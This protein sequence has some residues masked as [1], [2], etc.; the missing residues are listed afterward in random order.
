MAIQEF[1]QSLLADARKRSDDAARRRRKEEERAAILGV[2]V[3]LAAKIGN[4][5]LA[6]KAKDFLK[7]EEFLLGQRAQNK[8]L[9]YTAELNS[10]RNALEQGGEGYSAGDTVG[11]AMYKLRPEFEARA[12][13]T[14]SNTYTNDL[15]AY[16]AKVRQET[17]K[18]A[19][20]WAADYNK[21]ILLA[22]EVSDKDSYEAMVALN[23]TKAKP[24]NIGGYVTRGISK[25]FGGKSEEEFEQEAFEAITDEMED[26]EELT[27]FM[28]TFKSFGDMTRA[29]QFT[30]Q[31]FP[32]KAFSPDKTQ[33]IQRTPDVHV[34]DG[35]IFVAEKVKTTDLITKDETET[36]EFKTD[37]ENR[38]VPLVD[39][40]DPEEALFKLLKRKTDTFNYGVRAQQMLTAP[41]FEG[42]MTQAARLELKP[43]NPDTLDE[44]QKIGEL[45]YAWLP[46]NTK[47][48][49]DEQLQRELINTATTSIITTK[50]AG[51]Q[52]EGTPEQQQ[53][54]ISDILL[55]VLL[56][57]DLTLDKYKESRP[58][59]GPEVLDFND[60]M[61]QIFRSNNQYI[62]R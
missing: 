44:Y 19:E 9:D 8:A 51:Q 37:A 21:A 54:A 57:T 58:Q 22:D 61:Q 7:R 14:L 26:A 12:K 23:A 31:V 32:E 20:E 62:S 49:P 33:Q 16:N 56:G 15:T 55:N 34:V 38:P 40:T 6:S 13:E 18:L 50:L 3:N 35:K 25:L 27:T 48:K 28:S 11:Y 47:N 59:I 46:N 29:Y 24:T 53:A 5:M 60:L 45:F 42:F 39:T 36:L 4:E 10:H 41:A 30:K 1:G 17:Q 52:L 43:E 2:G